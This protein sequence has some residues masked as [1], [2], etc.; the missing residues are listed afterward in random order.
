MTA[1]PYLAEIMKELK[2]SMDSPVPSWHGWAKIEEVLARA[3]VMPDLQEVWDQFAKFQPHW[4]DDET[5]DPYTKGVR[6]GR[7]AE[8]VTVRACLRWAMVHQP[9][10]PG[11]DRFYTDKEK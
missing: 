9:P 5:L 11:G 4:D 2:A 8:W 1:E 6:D 3:N 7:A 10:N